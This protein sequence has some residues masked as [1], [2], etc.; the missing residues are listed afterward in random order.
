[1]VMLTKE[2]VGAGAERELGRATG[3]VSA[4][5]RPSVLIV[6]D[7]EDSASLLGE[8]LE[9]LQYEVAV[10]NDGPSALEIAGGRQ[11]D[12]ALLDIGLPMMDG[13][14]LARR[15]RTSPS[16]GPRKLVAVTGYG[17]DTEVAAAKAAGFSAH[18]MKPVD[19]DNLQR[20][21]LELGSIKVT[22]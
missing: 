5:E 22:S 2:T 20:T 7:N 3:A 8:V 21:L 4:G 9:M 1:M 6:D 15:L 14:E 12:F 13:Y 17:R 19:I 18:V 16:G 11:F 10:A